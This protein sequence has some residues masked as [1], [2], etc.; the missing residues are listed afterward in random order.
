[1]EEGSS[2]SIPVVD[3]D[4][5]SSG[6]G[7]TL[8]ISVPPE[9]GEASLDPLSGTLLY[10]PRARWNGLD[11]L[12]YR[13][14]TGLGS[15]EAEVFIGVYQTADEGAPLVLMP[16]LGLDARS[17]GLVINEADGASLEVGEAYGDLRGIPEENR[18]HVTLPVGETTISPEIFED[19]HDQVHGALPDHVQAIAVAWTT[20]WRVG[21]MSITSALAL[22]YDDGYCHHSAG[23]EAGCQGTTPVEMYLSPTRQP[24]ADLGLRPAM[25]L[26]GESVDQVLELVNRSAAAD[27]TAPQ[28]AAYLVRTQDEARSIRWSQMLSAWLEWEAVPGLNVHYLDN[29]GGQVG[30]DLISDAGD[31]LFYFTG[32]THVDDLDTNTYLAGAVGDHLT[33][34]GGQLT[35][36][37]QMSALRWLETGMSASYGTV[38]EPC[39]LVDKFPNVRFVLQHYTRGMSA[40]E[41]YWKS[42]KSPGEGVFIGDP[43]TNPWGRHHLTYADGALRIETP[44]L[45]PGQSLSVM[46]GDHPD[47]P[48]DTVVAEISQGDLGTTV[49]HLKDLQHTVFKSVIAENQ[50]Q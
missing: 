48:W 45:L 49:V 8:E 42:V 21:C 4:V 43:L 6:P 36:S 35:D 30:S 22:G 3:N 32:L 44:M 34:Y 19:I 29:S 7:R 25:L 39:N 46:A 5:N 2:A 24:F 23:G 40:V 14:T 1:M 41:A 47:G 31:V 50:V 20:P 18:V 17:L 38:V 13:V 15:D 9:H 16:Q 27:R 28:G 26:A 11:R 37:S 12:T 10:T 33:S